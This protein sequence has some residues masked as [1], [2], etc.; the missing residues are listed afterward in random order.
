[1]N[2]SP[3]QEDDIL[4]GASAVIGGSVP[5]ESLLTYLNQGLTVEEFLQDF[6]TVDREEALEK[7]RALRSD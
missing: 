4:W 2:R 5:V 7:M 3:E 6:P 1:M